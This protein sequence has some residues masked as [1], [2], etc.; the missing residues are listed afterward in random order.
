MSQPDITAL[1]RLLAA[2]VLLADPE[3]RHDDV[4]KS[5]L[6]IW[7]ERLQSGGEDT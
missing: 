2:E 3:A 7:R 1:P 6:Y 4:L 5:S